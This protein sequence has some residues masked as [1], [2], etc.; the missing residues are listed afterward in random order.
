MKNLLLFFMII[1]VLILKFYFI[2]VICFFNLC[3]KCQ[4]DIYCKWNEYYV[5]WLNHLRLQFTKQYIDKKLKALT[6]RKEVA[7][8]KQ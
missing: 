8:G 7:S 1:V 3:E 2:R 5:S 6:G 4:K